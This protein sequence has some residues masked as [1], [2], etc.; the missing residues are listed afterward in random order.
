MIIKAK[1]RSF[2]ILFLVFVIYLIDFAD[3]KVMSVLFESIKY[4]WNITDVQLSLLEGVTSLVIAVC[5]LPMAIAI[6]RWSRKYMIAIMVAAWSIITFVCAFAENYT[7]LLI[8]RALIGIGEA[9]YAPAAVSLLSK[10]F[11]ARHRA[12]YIG[13]FDAAAP[14]GVA[15][16]MIV[17]GYIGMIYGWRHAFGI[18]AI[19]GIICAILALRIRDY[20]SIPVYKQ[21]QRVPFSVSQIFEIVRIKTLWFVSIAFSCMVGINTAVLDWAP[22]F[23]MRVHSLTQAQAGNMSAIIAITALLGAPLGG[24]IADSWAKTQPYAKIYV[25][26]IVTVSAG[27][28][29]VLALLFTNIYWVYIWFAL[30]GMS[31]V[32]FLGPATAIIQEVVQ[33]GMRTIAFSINVIAIN[34][35]GAFCMIMLVGYISDIYG[36]QTSLIIISL[37]AFVASFL[38][39]LSKR[40]YYND[41]RQVNALAL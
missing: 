15:L 27:I 8:L 23:F 25:S 31:T 29:L 19:P 9:A 7:Q 6:D 3:R 24:F 37:F 22:S 2:Y 16:G 33:P 40:V 35:L 41:K 38:F 28:F 36:I 20:Y 1:H 21:S 5:V 30:F 18:V 10:S 14:L 13:I 39:L 26:A 32:A 11:P 17:G 4:D 34:I 12:K